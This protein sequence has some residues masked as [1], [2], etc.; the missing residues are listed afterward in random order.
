MEDS[1]VQK[2]TKRV[3]IAA[4]ASI[5]EYGLLKEYLE[6]YFEGKWVKSKNLHMT[7]KFLG[8]IEVDNIKSV[9]E[10]LK[11]LKYPKKQ[12]VYFKKLRVFHKKILSLRSSNKT[13]YKIQDQMDDLLGDMFIKEPEF[14]PHITLMRIKKIKDKSYKFMFK[15]NNIKAKLNIKVCLVESKLNPDGVK[16]KILREF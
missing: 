13:L 14:K 12:T 9:I 4:F 16:Y 11:K 15:E 3:F 8:D 2:K 5:D 7:F 1:I 6:P 10:R